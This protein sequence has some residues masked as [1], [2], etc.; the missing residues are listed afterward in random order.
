MELVDLSLIRINSDTGFISVHRLTQDEYIDYMSPEESIEAFQ[1]I[2]RLIC[3]AF[4]RRGTA[5]AHHLYH[6]WQSCEQLIHHVIAL[7]QGY[8]SVRKMGV[9]IEDQELT[10]LMADAAWFV[11]FHIARELRSH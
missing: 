4:P 6:L 8:Q 3:H 11:L 9:V 7:Q 5:S 1:V 2:C 10:Q